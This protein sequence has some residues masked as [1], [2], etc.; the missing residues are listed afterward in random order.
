[1]RWIFS[2]T[3]DES[4]QSRINEIVYDPRRNSPVSTSIAARDR[5]LQSYQYTSILATLYLLNNSIISIS[6]SISIQ[7][8]VN[9]LTKYTNQLQFHT[10]NTKYYLVFSIGIG[11]NYYSSI[12]YTLTLQSYTPFYS[13]YFILFYF[14]LLYFHFIHNDR[15]TMSHFLFVTARL[16]FLPE[17]SSGVLTFPFPVYSSYI[18]ILNNTNIQLYKYTYICSLQLQSATCSTYI[19][20]HDSA[21]A[22]TSEPSLGK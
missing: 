5:L 17:G 20:M 4:E 16:L 12:D 13:L 21:Y 14:T 10:V 15:P 2:R 6:I 1:M 11:I 9:Y 18:C 22:T 19:Q 3:T 8:S 7:Y